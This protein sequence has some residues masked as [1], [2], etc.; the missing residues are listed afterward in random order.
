MQHLVFERLSKESGR[1]NV[2]DRFPLSK[3]QSS[4]LYVVIERG[5][6]GKEDNENEE[7]SGIDFEPTWTYTPYK[8]PPPG[9]KKKGE[10]RNRLQNQ[11]KFSSRSDDWIVPNKVTIP[12]D[13]IEMTFARSSGAGGQNV[14][15]ARLRFAFCV[16]LFVFT[17]FSWQ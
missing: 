8:P 13:K 4:R 17:F 14:N 10:I 3:V 2:F 16:C 15:K 9:A 11:R 12:E 1:I 5:S 7:K 6:L